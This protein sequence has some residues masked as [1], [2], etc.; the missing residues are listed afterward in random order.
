MNDDTTLMSEAAKSW[1]GLFPWIAAGVASSWAFLARTVMKQRTDAVKSLEIKVDAGFAR[2][3]E[4]LD[5]QD[6]DIGTIM[7]TAST[8]D[9]A[10]REHVSQDKRRRR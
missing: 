10:F 5:E 4:R 1:P 7:R 6:R 3:H 9:G 2:L 8:L